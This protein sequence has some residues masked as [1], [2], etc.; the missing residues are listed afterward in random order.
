MRK[1]N[2]ALFVLVLIYSC[3][4]SRDDNGYPASKFTGHWESH[5]GRVEVTNLPGYPSYH[6]VFDTTYIGPFF[7]FMEAYDDSTYKTN[8]H[9]AAQKVGSGK[10]SIK[11]DSII[12]DTKWDQVRS[13][14]GTYI[15][16]FLN[17]DILVLSLHNDVG[18][19]GFLIVETDTF[20]KK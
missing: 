17:N 12:M 14:I 16:R 20:Y 10:Y 7:P 9:F 19:P 2:I 13:T 15:Y 18:S 8:F 4:K 11:G 5:G 6:Y 3:S 1:S